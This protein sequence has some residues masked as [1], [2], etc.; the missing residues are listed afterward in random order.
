M[1]M[2]LSVD[3]LAHLYPAHSPY[4]YVLNNP[5][6][7]TD[8]DGRSAKCESCP[9]SSEWNNYRSDNLNW[10]YNPETQTATTVDDGKVTVGTTRPDGGMTPSKQTNTVERIPED[11]SFG[12]SIATT[13]ICAAA[14]L[15]AKQMGKKAPSGLKIVS[16]AAGTLG[17]VVGFADN[18]I[19]AYNDFHK[20]NYIRGTVNIVQGAAYATGTVMLFTPL[21]PVGAA[22]LLGT[23]IS[24][25]IQMGAEYGTGVED[26]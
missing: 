18:S 26:Y 12:T 15:T 24:D 23:T 5:V 21:A 19:E 11:I 6:N 13:E 16:K 8:P 1:R 20:G 4:A 25:W 7:M 9:E 3:P 2:W 14:D 22:I 10:E 17:G